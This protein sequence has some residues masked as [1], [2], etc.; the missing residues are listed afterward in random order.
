ME[1]K[2]LIELIRAWKIKAK[3]LSDAIDAEKN[4]RPAN[5][6]QLQTL[7]EECTKHLKESKELA[8]TAVKTFGP[9]KYNQILMQIDKEPGWH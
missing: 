2:E 5:P 7:T 1:E 3:K 8:E 9:E 4:K 6:R